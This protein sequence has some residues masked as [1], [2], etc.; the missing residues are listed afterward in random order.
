MSKLNL[1]FLSTIV[2]LGVTISLQVAIRIE[3]V[4]RKAVAD[5]NFN[6]IF[7]EM[8]SI[9]SNQKEISSKFVK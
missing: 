7:K 3:Q 4:Q 9:K 8:D 5:R 2:L 1:A 6:N